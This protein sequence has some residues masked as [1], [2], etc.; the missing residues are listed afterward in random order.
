MVNYGKSMIY[1]LVCN[2]VNISDCYVGSTTNFYRRKQEHKSNCCNVNSKIY[3]SY[4]YIFIRANGGFEN[5][6]MIIIENYSCE[7]KR[8][9]E[10]KERY[11]M[12]LL[13]AT[14]N[15]KKSYL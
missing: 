3:N 7:N 1:K 12:E 2:D 13:N 5:W 4:K 8:E 9:L 14:L 15:T 11:F 6:S 10:K